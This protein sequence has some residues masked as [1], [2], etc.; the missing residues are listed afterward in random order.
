MNLSRL[1]LNLL[2]VFTAIYN[3]KTI[4]KAAEK[5]NLSQSAV[6]NALNRLRYTLDDDLFFRASDMMKPTKRAEELAY[7]IQNALD[8]IEQS[9][10]S[11]EFSPLTSERSFKFCLP[12]IAAGRILPQLAEIFQ[13]EAPKIEVVAVSTSKGDLEKLKNQE[14]DF[15]ISSDEAL[16]NDFK[17]PVGQRFDEYF[18]SFIIYKDRPVCV[19][20][21]G[22]PFFDENEV[23]LESY[24]KA[25]HVHVSYDG[26]ID[27]PVNDYLNKIKKPRRIAMSVNY[28]SVAK[29][30]VRSSDYLITL[31]GHLASFFNKANNF[32]I[33]PLPFETE[34]YSVRLIWNK[35]SD[36]E[37]SHSWMLNIL[38][39]IQERNFGK[40]GD[41]SNHYY[42][43]PDNKFGVPN[44][45]GD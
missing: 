12:D 19:G 41:E 23:S 17:S 32:V 26:T 4:T 7:P 42:K 27:S 13:T 33:A 31:S 35:R 18:N 44:I 5:L 29:E 9:L 25:S 11:E 2:L 37:A 8:Q 1:D 15:I 14:L 20:R 10:S 28:V 22:N 39:K 21:I 34:E 16:R 45:R 36:N 3:E 38:S 6:S 43:N 40:E 30:I 24:T